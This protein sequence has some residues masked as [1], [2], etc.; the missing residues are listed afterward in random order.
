[1]TIG[2]TYGVTWQFG[3]DGSSEEHILD[4]HVMKNAP[5]PVVLS[6]ELLFATNAYVDFDGYLVDEDNDDDADAYF[7]AIDVD[8]NHCSQGLY[9]RPPPEARTDTSADYDQ[10][11]SSSARHMELLRQGDEDDRI[12][13]LPP[14]K[15]SEA[16]A[17]ETQRRASWNAQQRNSAPTPTNPEVSIVTNSPQSNTGIPSMPP[18]AEKSPWQFRFRLRKKH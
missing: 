2:M 12:A 8:R 1:M 3:H 14:A 13:D 9:F 7:V 6:D 15:R 11:H 17:A 5:A 18:P 10:I 16:R 4:F